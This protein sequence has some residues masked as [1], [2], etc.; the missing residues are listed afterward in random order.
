MN[1]E[2]FFLAKRKFFKKATIFIFLPLS[3]FITFVP[4]MA[5]AEEERKK[6]YI[7]C[8]LKWGTRT[9]TGSASEAFMIVGKLCGYKYLGREVDNL[10]SPLR[11][12]FGQ[13]NEEQSQRN[14]ELRD[15]VFN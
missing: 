7:D 15:P 6:E 2:N 3:F 10:F 11:D 1:P 4:S 13:Q 8:V 12:N 9:N 14:Q 5:F